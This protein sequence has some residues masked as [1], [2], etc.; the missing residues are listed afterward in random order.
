M[1]T[2][3]THLSHYNV[4]YI[5]A[6]A[7]SRKCH[8]GEKSCRDLILDQTMPNVKPVYAIFTYYNMLKFQSDYP[9]MFLVIMY[10][11][12]HRA[13]THTQTGR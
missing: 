3:K 6:M 5:S 8:Y 2:K 13:H 9:I 12:T 4:Y 11:N 7:N 10:T 1:N